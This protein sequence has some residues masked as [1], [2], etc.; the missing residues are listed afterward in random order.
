MTSQVEVALLRL[1]AQRIAGPALA[2]AAE[3]VRWLA[4]AQ[5]QDHPGVLT[6]IALRTAAGTR[7]DVEAALDAGDVVK[8]WPMRGTLH[9][10]T[11]EDLPWMLS[12][13]GARMQAGAAARRTQLG[14]DARALERAERLAIDALRG[15]GQL[16]RDALFRRWTDDGLDAVGPR[17]AHLLGYLAQAG[18]VCFGPVQAGQQLIVL[19]NEWITQ[20]R[21]LEREPA[22]GEWAERYFRSHGPATARDF[23]RWTGLTAADV[24]T[25]LALARPQLA[26][27]DVD[28]AEH[29]MD[30]QTPELLDAH[31]REA[32]G[33]F[34]LPGFDE[35]L[36]GYADRSATV[37]PQYADRI[38]PGG[39]GM[40]RPTVIDQGRTVG[41]WR[42]SGRGAKRSIDA[43]AFTTFRPEVAKALPRRHAAL[44]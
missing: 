2:T 33:V 20:P 32:R 43:T 19:I 13:T 31:R 17:G 11:A 3:T 41:T 21:R 28:G 18:V 24:R 37:P 34:L 23:S 7:T 29:L 16:R 9:L 1:V 12:L 44:R 38:V 6:S 36:L 4:A 8:S 26:R 30:P 27:L 15:G 22:L 42:H 40:F 39:N 10:V 5:A 35:L 25:A 14:L